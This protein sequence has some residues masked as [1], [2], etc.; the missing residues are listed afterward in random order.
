MD[1]ARWS[2]IIAER[3]ESE[4]RDLEFL[5][6]MTIIEATILG[7][8]VAMADPGNM[9]AAGWLRAS[10]IMLL[11]SIVAGGSL[12]YGRLERLREVQKVL[13]WYV[14]VTKRIGELRASGSER[15]ANELLVQ[16]S[17]ITA[18]AFARLSPKVDFLSDTD[19]V[20]T[21]VPPDLGPVPLP[22]GWKERSSALLWMETHD[23]LKRLCFIWA[24]MGFLAL[25]I[26]ALFVRG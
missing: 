6:H 15:E 14:R 18:A 8:T 21:N 13:R 25:M 19:H 26:F 4:E 9:A 16:G 20:D 22:L 5:K 23:F 1:E 11:G 7:L 2:E 17:E 12:I 3:R 10:W 24:L